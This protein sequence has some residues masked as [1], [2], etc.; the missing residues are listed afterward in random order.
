MFC[1]A[2][3]VGHGLLCQSMKRFGLASFIMA[4]G[5]CTGSRN[6]EGSPQTTQGTGG[7]ASSGR[8]DDASSGR[9]DTAL[10]ADTASDSTS[11]GIEHADGEAAVLV[12]P[13]PARGISILDVTID[14]GVRIP[15]ARDGALLDGTAR[16]DAV[17]RNRP[18]VVRAF[19]DV[20][21]GYA[22]RPIMA[23]LF[24]VQVDGRE[25]ILEAFANTRP[26]S[27]DEG[28]AFYECGYGLDNTSFKWRVEGEDIQVGTRYRMEMVETSPGH[29]N[30]VSSRS[31]I[32]P[33]DGSTM[34][35]G[36]EDSY[37]KM[38]AVI[39]PLYHDI[40]TECA[41]APDLSQIVGKD[42]HGNDQNVAEYFAERLAAQNPVDEVT[43]T[44]HEPLAFR[45]SM[46]GSA[47]LGFLQ[48]LRLSENAPPEAFYYGLGEPCDGG[49]DFAG[50]AQLGAPTMASASQRVGWGVWGE[51]F[52]TPQSVAET[53]V[54]ELG[55]EQGRQHI[56]CSGTEAGV[57]M[58]YPYPGG[59]IGSWGTDAYGRL[60]NTFSPAASHD[61]MTY[62]GQT[63]VSDWGWRL[64][65]PWIRTMSEWDFMSAAQ[66]QSG[67]VPL[68]VGNVYADGTHNFY[69]TRGAV[70]ESGRGR[71]RMFTM[72]RAG[73]EIAVP[74]AVFFPW[75]HFPGDY[76]VIAPLPA[77]WDRVGE[78]RV[79]DGA[80]VHS[81][82][83]QNIV[84]SAPRKLVHAMPA[85]VVAG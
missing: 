6:T 33:E 65:F 55:H 62:C 7:G 1:L 79:R 13:P 23:R 37:M 14:Q 5:G 51:N 45:G 56:A 28:E 40:G 54:H 61:Y 71:Q 85:V 66:K 47:P 70:P 80:R 11:D 68:L 44:V 41:P 84:V 26:I 38:H 29:E 76:H 53:F 2:Y 83:R 75:D 19:Y 64:V 27:C 20:D 82:A 60:M 32:F 12:E 22:R 10:D 58:R 42:R 9:S 18:G 30:D 81:V 34:L 36:V 4:L 16:T 49:P 24:V 73:Q 46:R 3:R 39:V 59:V 48:N 67:H 8:A 43:L 21:Q 74:G 25:T 17:L 35:I 78:V 69:V 15:I 31:P 63:W 72:L 50:V 57:D 77:D 52:G